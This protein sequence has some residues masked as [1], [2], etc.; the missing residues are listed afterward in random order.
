MNIN[1]VVL[2]TT[3]VPVALETVTV[4]SVGVPGVAGNTTEVAG[5]DAAEYADQT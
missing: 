4:V 3:T 5:D 2:P 1:P